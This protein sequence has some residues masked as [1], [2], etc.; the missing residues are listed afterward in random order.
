[1]A[2]LLHNRVSNSVSST[3]AKGLKRYPSSDDNLSMQSPKKRRI[4]QLP[5]TAGIPDE[6]PLPQR[7]LFSHVEV[8]HCDWAVRYLRTQAS[9]EPQAPDYLLPAST[10]FKG[11]SIF[12]LQKSLEDNPLCGERC[13]ILD[14]FGMFWWNNWVVCGLHTNVKIIPLSSLSNHLQDTSAHAF[15]VHRRLNTGVHKARQKK[16]DFMKKEDI[17]NHFVAHVAQCCSI[18]LEQ[19][20]PTANCSI[21]V[22]DLCSPPCSFDSRSNLDIGPR[23]QCTV[24]ESWVPLTR[25]KGHPTT[26]LKRHIKTKHDQQLQPK[27]ATGERTV[28]RLE[29]YESGKNRRFIFL[30]LPITWKAPDDSLLIPTSTPASTL[31]STLSSTLDTSTLDTSTLDTST[32]D[33]S[34]LDTSTLDTSTFPILKP[35]VPDS[36]WLPKTPWERYRTSLG[37]FSPK[38]LKEFVILPSWDLARNKTSSDRQLEEGLVQLK[39]IVLLYLQESLHFVGS[40]PHSFRLLLGLGYAI[41]PL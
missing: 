29:V 41:Q 13:R 25:N 6:Q 12:S 11:P 31:S 3:L 24:C 20:A 26:E 27:D 4:Q 2:H 19:H 16:S 28:Q 33:T 22:D 18:P 39:R 23:Y 40:K 5:Q 32:L 14:F 36:S 9:A 38:I 37:Q 10:A 35:R 30:V 7:L 21:E 34:T 1:M 17:I 15:S 8:P